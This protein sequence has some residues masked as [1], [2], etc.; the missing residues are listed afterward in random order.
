MIL[1][2]DRTGG[3]DLMKFFT[4]QDAHLVRQPYG[5]V[6]FLGNGPDNELVPVGIEVKTVSDALNS[7]TDG[8]FAGHQ[9]PGLIENYECIYLV[10]EGVV[11]MDKWGVMC[12]PR[13]GGLKPIEKAGRPFMWKDFQRWLITME[14]QGGVKVRLTNSRRETG[15]FILALYTWWHNKEWD[16]HKSLLVFDKS[17]RPP[18]LMDH[19]LVVRVA[20]EFWKVGWKKAEA[21]GK[22]FPTVLEMCLAD[23]DEWE[24]I[25]GI[26][27]KIA[28][29]V[30]EEI[31]E[32]Q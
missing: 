25:E 18:L 26:G 29:K 22:H 16:E 20:K 8:R 21:V 9:L 2:D 1:V 12:V 32:K 15:Y 23:A 13:R 30:V 5:D 24:G 14:L 27:K 7:L 11:K 4:Y 6:A 3:E 31:R 19:P 10:I 28:N 17:H